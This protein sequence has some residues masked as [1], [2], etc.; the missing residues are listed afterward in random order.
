VTAEE[1]EV[2]DPNNTTEKTVGLFIYSLPPR[3]IR[4]SFMLIKIESDK[5]ISYGKKFCCQIL[6]HFQYFYSF[7][8]I[9][10]CNFYDRIVCLLFNTEDSDKKQ[11]FQYQRLCHFYNFIKKVT[12]LIKM[13]KTAFKGTVV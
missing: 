5:R 9:L 2:M 10:W 11:F 4:L 3:F 13:R 6:K 12:F 8:A 7:G 1:E